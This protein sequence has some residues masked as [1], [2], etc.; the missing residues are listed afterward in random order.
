M[1]ILGFNIGA[2]EALISIN[3]LMFLFTMISPRIAIEL[4]VLQPKSLLTHPWTLLTSMFVHADLIHIMFNMIALYFFGL[5]LERMVGE[6]ELLKVYFL[7]GIVGGIFYAASSL[8]LGI[9]NPE[10]MAVGASGAIFAVAGALAILQPHMRVVMIP[11]FIPMPLYIAVFIFMVL[12]SF[13]PGVAWQGH[14]GG[15]AVGVLF[16]YYWRKRIVEVI[17]VQDRYGYKFY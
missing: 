7:G 4:L 10:S 14:L 6:K 17:A 2:I 15:L 3:A 11:I 12:L 9:P 1:R 16:G 8:L 13:M 5:Y